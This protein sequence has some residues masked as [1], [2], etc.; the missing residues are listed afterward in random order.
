[1]GL[2]V[3]EEFEPGAELDLHQLLGEC[4]RACRQ[5]GF[6]RR[7]RGEH[8]VLAEHGAECARRQLRGEGVGQ[9]RLFGL[10]GVLAGDQVL[11]QAANAVFMVAAEQLQAF[12]QIIQQWHA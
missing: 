12:A 11:Q 1:M 10:C 8:G 9:L 3:R 5:T 4:L 2:V 7:Q 6:A